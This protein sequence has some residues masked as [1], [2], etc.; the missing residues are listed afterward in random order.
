MS[1]PILYDIKSETWPEIVK[2]DVDSDLDIHTI[3]QQCI[4]II[5]S[6]KNHLV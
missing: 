2:E 6:F 3:Y 1:N 4:N 5:N